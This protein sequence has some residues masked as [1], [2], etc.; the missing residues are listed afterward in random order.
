MIVRVTFITTFE[1]SSFIHIPLN[2]MQH[3]CGLHKYLHQFVCSV[4]SR[5]CNRR[6]F[7][8]MMILEMYLVM[9]LVKKMPFCIS[10][11]WF[12]LNKEILYDKTT[13]RGVGAAWVT[14]WLTSEQQVAPDCAYRTPPPI[15]PHWGRSIV[16]R[17]SRKLMEIFAGQFLSNTLFVYPFE[18]SVLAIFTKN[19]MLHVY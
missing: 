5:K 4:T 13:K 1:T 17:W 14:E 18:S 8:G 6:L 7:V 19:K 3:I 9:I 16:L 11:C 10:Q 12:C 15:E 2:E